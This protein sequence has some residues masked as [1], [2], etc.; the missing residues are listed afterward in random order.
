M[1]YFLLGAFV[2]ACTLAAQSN[3]DARSIEGHVFNSVT[4]APIRK[5]TVILT[6]PKITAR[7]IRLVADTDA[8]REVP[9]HR[10][11]SRNLPALRES[12][13]ILRSPGSP[14]RLPRHNR[15]GDGCRDPA[16]S[17]KRDRG[18]HPG[19]RWR[20]GWRRP[21]IDLQA[22]LP[23]RQGAVG[24]AQHRFPRQRYR[25]IPLSKS[26]H[27]PLP[28]AGPEPAAGGETWKAVFA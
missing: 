6:N 2:S 20:P 15:P 27:R 25:R 1:K 19:R 12:L 3:P 9:V 11:A 16:A 5:A 10:P 7:Q 28:V 4:S 17:A 14:P 23:R 22:G 13:R 24:T 8:R 26:H 18:S 21:R